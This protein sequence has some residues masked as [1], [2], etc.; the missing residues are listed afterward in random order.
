MSH[1]NNELDILL[2]Q[3]NREERRKQKKKRKT[4]VKLLKVTAVTII[5]SG[6]VVAG[7]AYGTFK[8]IIAQAPSIDAL[9]LKPMSNYTSFV[10]DNTGKQIASFS[11]S[12]NRVYAALEQIPIHL[13]HAFISLEDERFY[14]HNGIDI[15]GIGRALIVNLKNKSMSEGASTITQQ[16]IKNNILTSEKK[17]ERKI[18]EQYLAVEFE[19]L[20]S[21]D[22]ILEYYLNTV[23]LGQGVAGVQSASNRY[24]GKDV[25]ELNLTE[26]VVLSVITQAPTRYNPIKNPENNWEKVK[27]ALQKMEEQGYIT[28]QEHIEALS[29]DPYQNVQEVHGEF[30]EKSTQSYFVDTVFKQVSQ[31]LQEKYSLTAMQ[32]SHMIYGGGLK[33]YSTID[34]DMQKITDKYINDSSMY[35]SSL[36]E[37]QLDYSVSIEKADGTVVN[38]TGM[39][40]VVKK[41]SEIESFRERMLKEVGFEEGDKIIKETLIKQPQPQAAIVVSDFTTGEVKAMTGGR[42]DKTNLGFNFVIDAQRQPGSVFKPLAAYAPALDLGLL[43]DESL[44]DD[45]PWSVNL[46]N[47]KTYSPNNWDNRYN[48]PTSMRKAIYHSMNVLAVKTTADIVG[49]DRAYDY[50]TKFGFTTLVN[51]DKNYSLPLGGLT[52]GVTALELNAAYGTIANGGVYVQPIFYT[53]VVDAEGNVL[54]DNTTSESIASRSYRVI[55]KEAAELLTDMMQEVVTVG[56]GKK[57]K[58]TFPNMPV[59]GKTGTTSDSKDLVFAGYTPYYAATIWTGYDQPKTINGAGN[60]HLTLWGSIMNELHKGLSNK[61]FAKAQDIELSSEGLAMIANKEEPEEEDP[62]DKEDK[63]EEP[64]TPIE[65]QTTHNESKEETPL[66]EKNEAEIVPE[67]ENSTDDSFL[68]VQD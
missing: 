45:A 68:I 10:Y 36:Y 3:D 2:K 12:D 4:W 29:Y 22:T 11:P 15:K 51:S 24:F 26:C 63:L 21:K 14:E 33:I 64:V 55:S 35:P 34:S 60:Y 39:R 42:G 19:K 1:S 54:L 40:E 5:I 25:S 58:S 8:A 31:D 50:L 18:M 13:Q 59:A 57:I 46:P 38:K 48:G 23:A 20:Y 43:N 66:P 65:D 52:Y 17:L 7:G 41:D 47:G 37:L 9:E 67:Q 62:I 6:A 16:L 28:R 44:I 49:T 30:I 56:T 61:N 27:I 53:K 32:V